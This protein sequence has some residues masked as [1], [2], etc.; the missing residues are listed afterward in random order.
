MKSVILAA[1][2]GT[3]MQDLT[4]DLPKPM[5]PVDGRPILEWIVERQTASGVNRLCIITGHRADVIE[6]HFGD[7]A[8]FGVSIC[9]VRQQVQNGTGKAPEL[10]REFVATDPFLLTYGDILV[11]ASTYQR[12]IA[13]FNQGHFAGLLTVTP[14]EDVTK[15]GIVFID[16]QRCMARIVEKPNAHQLQSFREQGW[17]K[18]GA[19]VWYNAGLYIFQPV[20]FDFTA[21]LK[22]SARGE[23]ELPDALNA[24]AE[25]GHKVAAVETDGSW[26]DV[27]DP[28]VLAALGKQ[29]RSKP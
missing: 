1:G 22:P 11:E 4:K 13:R 23:Y 3:R 15:G 20:L 6:A 18:A 14:G 21:Q 8:Q 28:E 17:L 12:M 25:A 7:G 16:E 19:P 24:M 29:R 9:Y 2:K 5:L 27:R 26:A 10:A